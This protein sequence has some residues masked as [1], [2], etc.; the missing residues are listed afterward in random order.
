MYFPIAFEPGFPWICARTWSGVH[1]RVDDHGD[2]GLA[3]ACEG[4]NPLAYVQNLLLT[5]RVRGDD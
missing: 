2:V 5:L 4:W 1:L 3:I